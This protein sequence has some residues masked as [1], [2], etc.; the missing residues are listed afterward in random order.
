MNELAWRREAP[1]RLQV[2]HG[3]QLL[4]RARKTDCSVQSRF[5]LRSIHGAKHRPP[6]RVEQQG[7]VEVNSL[8]MRLHHHGGPVAMRERRSTSAYC[9]HG[10]TQPTLSIMRLGYPQCVPAAP[11]DCASSCPGPPGAIV[12]YMLVLQQYISL[13][14]LVVCS[15]C[16]EAGS[17]CAFAIYQWRQ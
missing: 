7:C 2:R 16:F 10:S 1:H 13:I 14:K 3:D 17:S 11:H 6:L 12:T 4:D 8:C 5:R 15:I 9:R